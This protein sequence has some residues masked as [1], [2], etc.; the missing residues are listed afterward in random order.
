ML[1]SYPVDTCN[2]GNEAMHR[3]LFLFSSLK[4]QDVTLPSD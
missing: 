2:D 1:D 3:I 4:S